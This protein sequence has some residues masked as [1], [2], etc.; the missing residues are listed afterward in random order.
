LN[1][2]HPRKKDKSKNDLDIQSNALLLD[3]AG[4]QAGGS[5]SI[6]SAAS[7]MAFLKSMES[8]AGWLSPKHSA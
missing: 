3:L 4:M 1:L 7:D 8:L 5:I 2:R 6:M